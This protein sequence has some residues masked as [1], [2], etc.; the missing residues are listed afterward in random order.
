VDAGVIK[1]QPGPQTALLECPCDLIFFGGSRGS[2]KTFASLLKIIQHTEQWGT[3]SSVLVVRRTYK[4]L[5][6]MIKDA[7]RV[8]QPLGAQWYGS[9]G[10]FIMQNGA[11]VKFR[12]LDSDSDADEYQGHSYSL[13][14]AEELGNFP[15]PDPINKLLATLRSAHGIKCQFMATGNPGGPGHQWVK[16]MFIDPAPLGNRVI[17]TVYTDPFT[18]QSVTRTRTFIPGTVR[19]NL[20][21]NPVEYAAQ[22]RM[23]GNEMLVKAWL[24]G[25]WN[26]VIGA[27]FDNWD[28]RKH[29]IRSFEIPRHWLRF[30]AGDWGSA[31]PFAIG[32]FAVASD[33]SKISQGDSAPPSSF[34]AAP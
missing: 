31:R 34:R 8:F 33:T 16:A 3:Y 12:H 22:L 17:S 20:Y 9:E 19:D 18:G 21:L 29:V 10:K 30:R 28:P 26:I 23:V 4:Q 13:L 6:D 11:E 5:D 24:F 15:S 14:I 1:P 32:W 7:K 25:D 2:G 27:F